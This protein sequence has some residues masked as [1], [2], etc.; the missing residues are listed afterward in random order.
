MWPNANFNQISKFCFQKFWQT[1]SIMVKVQAESFNLN[2]H[3]IG[4][5]PQTQKLES[6]CKTLSSTLAVKGLIV[7]LNFIDFASN[8][9]KLNTEYSLWAWLSNKSNIPQLNQP[10]LFDNWT[11]CW[12]NLH[13][14][15]DLV[16]ERLIGVMNTKPSISRALFN[17]T[18]N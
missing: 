17:R 14:S 15:L 12:L 18:A 1:N 13:H 7:W 4:F 10:Q 9:I 2:G 5:H 11:N 16:W 3:I 8:Q 6:P